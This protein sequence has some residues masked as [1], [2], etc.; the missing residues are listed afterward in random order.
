MSFNDTSS[1][2]EAIPACDTQTDG[3]NN[4]HINMARCIHEWMWARDKKTHRLDRYSTCIICS[5]VQFHLGVWSHTTHLPVIFTGVCLWGTEEP[6]CNDGW[7]W[8]SY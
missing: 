6:Q 5:Y 3:Q 1:R 4:C 8:C 7:S 2:F